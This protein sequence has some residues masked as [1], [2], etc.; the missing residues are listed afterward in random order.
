MAG[1]NINVNVGAAGLAGSIQQQVNQAQSALNRR[2]LKLK[3]DPKGFTQPLGRISGDIGEF[4]KSLDA[5]VARTFAFGAAVGVLNKV[6]DAFKALVDST[7]EVQRELKNINVLLGLSATQLTG[8]SKELFA[9]AKNTA[10]S[11]QTVA[12]AATE[13]SRQGLSAE[14]TLKRVNDAMVLT[15]LSG[16]S[17]EQSVASLT[18]AINGFRKEAVTSTEV[19][20]KLANVDANFAVSSKD[21][22]DGLA[23][24]GS[25]AQGAK[26]QFNELL[27]AV[28]AVQQSTARGGAVIGN[29]FKSIFTRIQRSGVQDALREIG[30][31]SRNLDGSFRSGIAVLRDYAR[32]YEGLTD[33]QKAYT[34]E[35]IAGVFQINNLRALVADLNSG[36]SVYERALSVANNT[37]NEATIRNKDLNTTLA[38]MASQAGTSFKA[39]GAAIGNAGAAEGIEKILKAV[40]SV[41]EFFSKVLDP[42]EGSAF[43]R[44]FFSGIGDFI[45][46]PGLIIIGGAFLKLFAFISKQAAGAV[47][48]I[49]TINTETQRQQQ[50][51]QSILALITSEEGIYRKITANAGNQAAQ[52]TIILNALKAQT[53]QRAQQAQFLAQMAASPAFKGLAV[54]GGVIAPRGGR[55]GRA[56]RKAGLAGGF[57]PNFAGT[58]QVVANTDEFLVRNFAATQEAK[59]IKAGVGGASSGAKVSM[60]GMNPARDAILNPD[61]VAAM[62]LPAGAQAIGAAGGF[63]PNFAKKTSEREAAKKLSIKAG[64]NDLGVI[65]P[66]KQ[67]R[68]G[69]ALS[70]TALRRNVPG[71]GAV[72]FTVKGQTQ[73]LGVGGHDLGGES[74]AFDA[75]L[76]EN[77][78]FLDSYG[79][80]LSLSFFKRTNLE[81]INWVKKGIPQSQRSL[82]KQVQTVLGGMRGN[83]FEEVI[84]N[85][86][87]SIKKEEAGKSGQDAIDINPAARAGPNIKRPFGP[88]KKFEIKAGKFSGADISKK[89]I[90]DIVNNMGNPAGS[91]NATA[92][93]QLQGMRRGGASGGTSGDDRKTGRGLQTS[94]AAF[95][96]MKGSKSFTVGKDKFKI[97]NNNL[98]QKIDGSYTKVYGDL[99]ALKNKILMGGVAQGFLPNFAS[100]LNFQKERAFKT[101]RKMGGDPALDFDPSIGYFVRDKKRQSNFAAVKRDHPEGLR[102]A[103]GNSRLM[104]QAASGIIP[105][106]AR[107]PVYTPLGEPVP[108]GYTKTQFI[109]DY[110]Q[111]NGGASRSAGEAAW[112]NKSQELR[113]QGYSGKG[114]NWS[115]P[116]P[117]AGVPASAGAAPVS[118]PRRRRR[119]P[120]PPAGYSYKNGILTRSTTAA[121]PTP[122][123]TTTTPAA[124]PAPAAETEKERRKRLTAEVKK[125]RKSGKATGLGTKPK[126]SLGARWGERMKGA[127]S[128]AMML[129]MITGPA[130]EAMGGEGGQALQRTSTALAMGSLFGPAGMGIGAAAGLGMSGLDALQTGS[131]ESLA[132]VNKELDEIAGKAKK[133][134]NAM[135]Q[136]SQMAAQ[137]NT[138][139]EEGNAENVIKLQTSMADLVATQIPEMASE[140]SNAGLS[141]EELGKITDKFN[142]RAGALAGMEEMG[143]GQIKSIASHMDRSV[144]GEGSLWGQISM[145]MG[146][147][148]ENFE[149]DSEKAELERGVVANKTLNLLGVSSEQLGDKEF[150]NDAFDALSEGLGPALKMLGKESGL[151]EDELRLLELQM[152]SSG[153]GTYHLRRALGRQKDAAEKMAEM[154]E[155]LAKSEANRVTTTQALLDLNKQIAASTSKVSARFATL[156]KGLQTMNDATLAGAVTLGTVSQDEASD[157]RTQGQIASVSTGAGVQI[158]KLLGDKGYPDIDQAIRGGADLTSVFDML[159]DLVQSDDDDDQELV[160]KIDG[161]L[162][163]SEQQIDELR[164]NN[165]I[166]KEIAKINAAVKGTSALSSK[167]LEKSADQDATFKDLFSRDESGKGANSR[168]G[169]ANALAELLPDSKVAS[170][171][172][173]EAGQDLRAANIKEFFKQ[174]GVNIQSQA[175]ESPTE[176]LRK[177]AAALEN[178]GK[179][180]LIQLVKEF[181][182][183]ENT[184]QSL[185]GDLLGKTLDAN[186]AFIKDLEGVMGANSALV[187]GL[188]GVVAGLTPIT[189]ELKGLIA[190][191]GGGGSAA[192]ANAHGFMPNF[193]GGDAVSKALSTEGKLGARKPVVDYHRSV[194]TYVRDGATQPNFA[195]VRRDHPEGIQKAI[196]NSRNLQRY[197]GAGF[198]PNFASARRQPKPDGP[199]WG[200]V[201]SISLN[202][203]NSGSIIRTRDRATGKILAEHEAEKWERDA[204]LH[205]NASE[206]MRVG[207]DEAKYVSSAKAGIKL[208]KKASNPTI[209]QEGVDQWDPGSD[210]AEE[211]PRVWLKSTDFTESTVRMGKTL[212]KEGMGNAEWNAVQRLA[213]VEVRKKLELEHAKDRARAEGG[214]AAE[215]YEWLTETLSQRVPE[216][217]D[218]T[219]SFDKPLDEDVQAAKEARK[220]ALQK[221][222]NEVATEKNA[223]AGLITGTLKDGMKSIL[224]GLGNSGIAQ[225]IQRL[226][227]AAAKRR[228]ETVGQNVQNANIYKEFNA[229]KLRG[230]FYNTALGLAA[231][232]GGSREG[233]PSADWRKLAIFR[234]GKFEK[235]YAGWNNKTRENAQDQITKALNQTFGNLWGKSDEVTTQIVDK[236]YRKPLFGGKAAELGTPTQ[237]QGLIKVYNGPAVTNERANRQEQYMMEADDYLH[238]KYQEYATAPSTAQWD[239]KKF[240][241]KKEE[242][243]A[244]LD[245]RFATPEALKKSTGL[246]F[247]GGSGKAGEAKIKAGLGRAGAARKAGMAQNRLKREF[248][249]NQLGTALKLLA[250]GKGPELGGLGGKLDREAAAKYLPGGTDHWKALLASG[251]ATK[252]WGA[253]PKGEKGLEAIRTWIMGGAAMRGLPG[254]GNLLKEGQEPGKPAATKIGANTKIMESLMGFRKLFA[255]EA[256]WDGEGDPVAVARF[257]SGFIPN[258]NKMGEVVSSIAAGYKNPVGL[259]D[260]KSMNIPGIGKSYYNTQESVVQMPGMQQPFIVPPKSSQAS[261][262]YANE[263]RGKFGFDPYKSN[264][265]QGFVPNFATTAGVKDLKVDAREFDKGVTSFEKAVVDFKRAAETTQNL[266]ITLAG[267]L[268]INMD[269]ATVSDQITK[270]VGNVITTEIEAKMID[271]AQEQAINVVNSTA[272]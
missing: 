90:N 36:F 266:A 144:I 91:V 186:S 195:A 49:F 75:A 48:Q 248:N 172:K 226:R 95:K 6:S 100:S 145:G 201:P 161:I 182:S 183:Q 24:A 189:E 119:L 271:I 133:S 3:L 23:R 81:N 113:R 233:F 228:G 41:A 138:A 272:R 140:L 244:S 168:V 239:G 83:L 180:D 197:F 84:L 225:G 148:R 241:N 112:N 162:K 40:T 77:K 115:K 70:P 62:G 11:F 42:N 45:T 185:T 74:N 178:S 80:A 255:K 135:S 176:V 46:G 128:M 35:Q 147:G 251:D 102:A 20:N 234:G 252:A 44:G 14:Q 101:E 30:V 63:L 4:Q 134:A 169:A 7:I 191:L 151:S 116:M 257:G 15:R 152:E 96:A 213:D 94:W 1:S 235:N 10:Q 123:T 188:N 54:Q 177:L 92:A 5:S 247:F 64:T 199:W 88:Y 37:T 66:D 120:A 57:L 58:Q 181:Q 263:V 65:T 60:V 56:A 9:V 13:F 253:A 190:V 250:E 86:Q 173:S 155:K 55:A 111:A 43:A 107:Q 85:L 82:T 268:D 121:A 254:G 256:G 237:Q 110:K 187:N 265:A 232:G 210:G 59:A 105:N 38:A 170:R 142:R 171:L 32:A 47:K 104:Q 164:V 216:V 217:F 16:L 61:M 165:A 17:A 269:W 25:T 26:V 212:T 27:A 21:L 149:R 33:A 131:G 129:P 97:E 8:F 78:N 137:L 193:A 179:T 157:L 130:A 117:L 260:V 174:Q 52:E 200:P 76:K 31:E 205:G 18:A 50:L 229:D 87:N 139:L 160:T 208:L 221:K 192:T 209:G 203:R 156:N 114:G 206:D 238:A 207:S 141:M 264:H 132:K 198:V 53:A 109:K 28:T 249:Q 2:P 222:E 240:V 143:A 246:G 223:Q 71:V 219:F 243:L 220:A 175:G 262:S 73:R 69:L 98:K 103:I 159:P 158:Q 127:S 106:F 124:A 122:T 230:Q 259:G 29:A 204:H 89:Y 202:T 245:P 270:A 196:N 39:L 19:I 218:R 154:H 136:Y 125:R 258:F 68:G 211:E 215:Y 12:T 150:T 166:A 22:A 267:N 167:L 34:S 242:I 184:A 126:Q 236:V 194:G 227:G 224:V 72:D 153:I 79:K 51:Q 67:G 231:T 118:T 163:N 214:R 99:P 93:K 146:F 108:Q 261:S